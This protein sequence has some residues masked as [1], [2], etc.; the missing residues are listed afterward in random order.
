MKIKT[1]ECWTIALELTEPF[2][3][4]YETVQHFDNVILKATTDNGLTGWSCGA[5]DQVITGE[6]ADSVMSAFTDTI[7]PI[8]RGSEP[9][10]Y[11]KIHA[12]LQP[13]LTDQRAALAMADMLLYDLMARAAQQPLY[14]L[15]GGFRD[16]IMTSVTIGIMPLDATL[17]RAKKMV[18]AGF[19]CL[20]IKGGLDVDVDIEKTLKV[21]ESVGGE[22]ELRFDG[23]Q[24]Y[25]V[26]DAVKFVHETSIA[27]VELLE[28]PTPHDLDEQLGEVVGRTAI[29]IMAD[30]S[31]KN[32][33]D[34]FRLTRYDRADMINIKLMKVGGITIASHISSVARAASVESMVGCLEE[35]ELGIAFGLHFCLSRPNLIY[36]DLDSSLDI[37]C[38]PFR[39]L[40][41]IEKGA[42]FPSEGFGI[43]NY[44]D[45]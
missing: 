10:R 25:S 20:K 23:N 11:A 31:L 17:E 38:D 19:R 33:N 22:V 42:L 28:Q 8:L 36:A 32:L 27:K 6:T 44:T 4:A 12:A 26:E 34:V 13:T 39:G 29:P 35:C 24:G 16:S 3:I 9:F 1:L 37:V 21:R 15:L 14:K 5:P 41:R 18:S 43:G 40:L 30:E 45:A 2:Q 7:E